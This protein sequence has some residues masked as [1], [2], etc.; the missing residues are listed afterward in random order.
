[1]YE[2]ILL[3]VDGSEHSS[4]ATDAAAELATAFHSKLV[5]VH[6]RQDVLSAAVIGSDA[7]SLPTMATGEQLVMVEQEL[8]ADARQL[9]DRITKEMTGRKIT[10]RGEVVSGRSAAKAILEAARD[11]DADLIVIGSRGLS[12][13]TGLL[14]GSVAHQVVQHAQCPVLVVR[15]KN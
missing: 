8:D 7:M 1:M 9:V 10:A 14:V 6:A 13:L 15:G 3:A 4:G 2:V 11:S 5:V 12:D